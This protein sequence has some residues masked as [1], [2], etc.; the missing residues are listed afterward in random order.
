MRVGEVREVGEGLREVHLGGG[1]FA[2]IFPLDTDE[3]IR[4][5]V[6][7][8][9]AKVT[10]LQY[11]PEDCPHPQAHGNVFDGFTCDGCGMPLDRFG[12]AVKE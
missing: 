10:T 6:R 11:S 8:R 12:N 1:R 2:T 3:D 7:E 5:I 9:G 4:R